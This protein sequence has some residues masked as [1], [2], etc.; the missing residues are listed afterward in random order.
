MAVVT[1]TRHVPTEARD[2]VAAEI[3][4]IAARE[5]ALTAR[6]AD[7]FRTAL[8]EGRLVVA[9]DATSIVGFVLAERIGPVWEAASLFVVPERR[10]A[11]IFTELIAE[12][13]Q[14]FDADWIVATF[15]TRFAAYLQRRR[16]YRRISI[17]GAIWRSRGGFARGRLHRERRAQVAQHVA[18]GRP[19][20]LLG[21]R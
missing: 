12:C 17:V 9:Q 6:S 14:I 15:D 21:R 3:A 20:I 16:G 8:A 7:T 1:L 10:G 4:R 5:P 2:A 18:G 19:V 11:A 13:E